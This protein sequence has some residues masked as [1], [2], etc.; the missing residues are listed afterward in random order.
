MKTLPNILR[1][2]LL[3]A[4]GAGLTGCRSLDKPGS[5]GFASVQISGHTREQV[6]GAVLLE[7][8]QDGYTAVEVRKPDM[9]FEKEGTR[10]DQIAYGGWPDN[11]VWLRVKVSVAALPGSVCLLE[12]QAF[13]VRGKGG[14]LES[15]PVPLKSRQN[16]PYQA[17][18][19]KVAA[20]MAHQ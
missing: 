6:R 19:D 18:L 10:W 17:V 7:F 4:A 1:A 9:V 3:I 14:P 5:G 13:R 8:E 12:C 16:K 2:L 11:D 15:E 20:R